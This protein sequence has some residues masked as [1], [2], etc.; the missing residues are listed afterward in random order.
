MVHSKLTANDFRPLLQAWDRQAWLQRGGEQSARMVGCLLQRSLTECAA[1]LTSPLRRALRELCRRGLSLRMGWPREWCSQTWIGSRLFLAPARCFQ[2]SL[3]FAGVAC[4]HLGRNQQQFRDWPG[5]MQ[6]ALRDIQAHSETLMVVPK[7]TLAT[8]MQSFAQR[9]GMRTVSLRC[10]DPQLELAH[11]LEQASE[12]CSLDP[13]PCTMPIWMSPPVLSGAPMIT[14][15]LQDAATCGLADRLF[16]LFIRPAGRLEGLIE[17]RLDQSDFP[18]ASVYLYLSDSEPKRKSSQR[19]AAA[20]KRPLERNLDWLDRGAV[21]WYLPDF[22]PARV[23]VVSIPRRS[24]GTRSSIGLHQLAAPISALPTGEAEW[25]FLSHCTRGN[26]GRRPHEDPAGYRTRLHL[27][28]RA[29][30]AH[31]LGTLLQICRDGSIRGSRRWTRDNQLAVSFSAVPLRDLLR[32][33]TYRAHLGRWDWEPYGVLIQRAALEELGARPVVYGD[34]QQYHCLPEG[35]RAYFQPEDERRRWSPEK[36]WRLPGN[37]ELANL[38]VSA[39]SLFVRS[40]SE[41]QMMARLY[42]WSVFWWE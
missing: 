31:P 16:A 28:G 38:P 25:C 10:S 12:Q 40:F 4:S 1:E 27:E 8:E 7:T 18:P 33:R 34:E 42:P 21:G 23:D 30:L 20:A 19:P 17:R 32:R 35:D 3:H 26:A 11:W 24:L 5:V 2:P 15:P 36:E 6:A 14:A 29:P 13:P 22:R 41:A 39:L 9:A 37:L